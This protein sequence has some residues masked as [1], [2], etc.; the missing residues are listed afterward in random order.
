[1][2]AKC[3]N[4]QKVKIISVKDQLLL[5][6]YKGFNF[7]R[8]INETCII[9]SSEY[10]RIVPITGLKQDL[11]FYIYTVRLDRDGNEIYV[12]EEALEAI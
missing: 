10:I 12:P 8:H 6:K 1:M 3:K 11:S 2:E 9:I 7:D 5:D 4:R